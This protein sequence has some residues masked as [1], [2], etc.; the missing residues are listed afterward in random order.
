MRMG[1]A[2]DSG[3]EHIR[4]LD[5]VDKGPLAGQQLR[6]FQP[7]QRLACVGHARPP[8]CGETGVRRLRRGAMAEDRPGWREN[9][10]VE[11]M[12]IHVRRDDLVSVMYSAE[13][14][15]ATS[16]ITRQR[17]DRH[18]ILAEKSPDIPLF[19]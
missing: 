1:A 14:N 16:S 18:G 17:T 9:L 8:C 15:S 12:G 13:L 19:S 7:F 3:V 11:F 6:V 4:E 10:P 2:E 5:V